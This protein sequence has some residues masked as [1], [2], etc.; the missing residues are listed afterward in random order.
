MTNRTHCE[1]PRLRVLFVV[2]FLYWVTATI[3]RQ[4]CRTNAWIEPTLCSWGVLRE[5][6]DLNGG[7]YPGEV[8]IVHFLTP[9]I[10]SDLMQAFR[11]TT[12]CVVAVHHVEDERSVAPVSDADAVMTVCRQ[13][14]DAL[15]ERG[16]PPD[17][18][19]M[20]PNGV[21][22]HLFV[23]A[24]SPERTKIRR[25]FGIPP[26]CF[27]VGFSGKRS[28]DTYK[29][30]GTDTL[31][32]AISALQHL[33]NIGL[34]V[35]GPGWSDLI[36]D[37]QS[38]GIACFYMPFLVDRS[39]V[40]SFYKALDAYWVTSRIEG[41]P[42]PLLE[43]MSSGVA[44]ISSPVGVALEAID[45]G[46][47]GFIVPFGDSK[48]Y[49]AITEQLLKNVAERTRIGRAARET[50]EARFQSSQTHRKVAELYRVAQR[51]FAF[52]GGRRAPKKPIH[53]ET[54]R[55][56]GVSQELMLASL[57]KTIHARVVAEEHIQF[58]NFLFDAGASRAAIRVA[59]RAIV[60]DPFRLYVW[61]NASRAW[62]PLHRL[63]RRCY[64]AL[65]P[66]N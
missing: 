45:P 16:V 64:R 11:P 59:G 57:P 58:A 14:H 34:V 61:W 25:K 40:A 47:N 4:I 6:L 28:S 13:W 49:A 48:A 52:R 53:G 19:V 66:R 43:A 29:R 7:V 31:V 39:A 23:P 2:D 12:P 42:I 55:T 10:A 62:P 22:S 21:D 50:T 17:K 15:L 20:V 41:G 32:A 30:K 37:L 56:N 63:L 33:E 38:R 27:C 65:V 44:C 18:C 3:A 26:E 60:A 8:D 46:V 36:G 35:V 54:V 24:S 51:N 9:H 1:R 5:I